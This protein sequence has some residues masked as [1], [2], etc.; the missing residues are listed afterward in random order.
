MHAIIIHAFTRPALH[1]MHLYTYDAHIARNSNV[2]W[3]LKET[4]SVIR[5][6]RSASVRS[7]KL[8]IQF[9][10]QTNIIYVHLRISDYY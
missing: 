5:Q 6:I 7:S 8:E 10:V 9:N 4:V 2:R 3:F 1:T